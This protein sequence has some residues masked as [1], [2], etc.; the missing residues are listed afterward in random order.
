MT[1]NYNDN[2]KMLVDRASF[3]FY[4]N[5]GFLKLQ[6]AIKYALNEVGGIYA[7]L[8]PNTIR[9]ISLCFDV[10][11]NEI[12]NDLINDINNQIRRDNETINY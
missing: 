10:D 1:T 3:L 11:I 6:D 8:S 12:E 4:A 2:Y 7:V 5:S 9:D